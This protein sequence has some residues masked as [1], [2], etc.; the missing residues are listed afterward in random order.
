MKRLF[1]SILFYSIL[2]SAV[3]ACVPAAATAASPN[4]VYV[5]FNCAD[6]DTA[7]VWLDELAAR[8]VTPRH[9]IAPNEATPIPRPRCC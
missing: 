8:G 2:F 9:V 3:L 1:N 5:Q 7:Q 6:Y 4:L